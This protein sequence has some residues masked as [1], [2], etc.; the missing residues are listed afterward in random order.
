MIE[1]FRKKK[2]KFHIPEN[3]SLNLCSSP[4]R[5]KCNTNLKR[6]GTAR[7]EIHETARY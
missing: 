2:G 7:H 6:G 3:S 5:L 1:E 4:L